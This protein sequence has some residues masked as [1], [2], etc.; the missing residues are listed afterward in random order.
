MNLENVT[1]DNFLDI[2][3]D[4]RK[5]ML[6]DR[7]AVLHLLKTTNLSEERIKHSIR[8]AETCEMLAPYHNVNRNDAYIC[9]LLHDC[10]KF[11]DAE[12]SGVLEDILRRNEPDKLN[13][14]TG[15]YHSWAAYYYLIEKLRYDDFEI[16]GAIYNH[17]ILRCRDRMS[18]ILFIADKREP[19]RHIY[20]DILETAKVD[21]WFA[22]DKLM[23][24]TE[25]WYKANGK[26]FIKPVL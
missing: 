19:G 21:L 15:A 1:F 26:E 4:I 9:G 23:D 6:Q 14:I 13:G 5:Q 24:K 2:D 17:T 12:T 10:C 25:K 7:E 16:L 18:L 8:V 22:Y 20:D 3:V 11:K